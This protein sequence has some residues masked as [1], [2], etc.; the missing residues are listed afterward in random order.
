MAHTSTPDGFSGALED[1]S[2]TDA[3]LAE[4]LGEPASGDKVA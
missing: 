3:A 1:L 2:S 4:A